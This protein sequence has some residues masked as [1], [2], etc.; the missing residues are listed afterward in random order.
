MELDPLIAEEEPLEIREKPGVRG[1]QFSNLEGESL[2]FAEG[3]EL[4]C[5]LTS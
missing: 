3:L 5:S 2:P 1:H 4:T